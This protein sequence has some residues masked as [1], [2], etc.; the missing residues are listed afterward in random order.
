MEVFL[1]NLYDGYAAD[2]WN[3]GVVLYTMVY[4]DLP[5]DGDSLETLGE[6]VAQGGSQE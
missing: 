5:F 3:V 4:G 6:Q 2:V 1:R